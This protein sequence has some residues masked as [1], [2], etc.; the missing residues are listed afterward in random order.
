M[1]ALNIAHMLKAEGVRASLREVLVP[2]RENANNHF[3]RIA[4]LQFLL[5]FNDPVRT[6]GKQHG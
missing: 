3:T 4:Q 1:R 5:H 6:H 2:L